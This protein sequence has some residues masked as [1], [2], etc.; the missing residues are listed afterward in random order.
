ME[1]EKAG[2]MVQKMVLKMAEWMATKKVD[3]KVQLNLVH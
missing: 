3:E 1:T 2:S